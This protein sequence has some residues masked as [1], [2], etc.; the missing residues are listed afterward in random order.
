MTKV[1]CSDGGCIFQSDETC[2]K[3][4]I[5]IDDHNMCISKKEEGS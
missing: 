2:H 4:E 5:V 3:E 1:R